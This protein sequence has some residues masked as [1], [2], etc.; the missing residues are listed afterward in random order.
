MNVCFPNTFIVDGDGNHRNFLRN[1]HE[2][3]VLKA[4]TQRS[5]QALLRDKAVGEF[6]TQGFGFKV[7][8][9]L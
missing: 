3:I 6:E 8:G 7:R 5:A 9:L 1:K 4:D 2:L